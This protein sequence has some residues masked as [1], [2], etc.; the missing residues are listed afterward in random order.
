LTL[1]GALFFGW[2]A[3]GQTPKD[4]TPAFIGSW[5]VFINK[6]PALLSV[7]N[8][9]TVHLSQVAQ[10]NPWR[11]TKIEV[12]SYHGTWKVLDD[13]SLQVTAIGLASAD[14]QFFG[15]VKFRGEMNLDPSGLSFTGRGE[16]EFVDINLNTV[17]QYVDMDTTLKGFK[18]RV[19]PMQINR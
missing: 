10:Y 7:H 12:S 9:G 19:E 8:D 16:V 3:L 18:I 4:Y 17:R 2:W 13:K 11:I 1:L 15:T 6:S 5:S 14:G